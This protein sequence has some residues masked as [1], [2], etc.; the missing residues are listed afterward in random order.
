MITM[1]Y[2][3]S[4]SLKILL[5]S[6]RISHILNLAA[7]SRHYPGMPF[8]SLHYIQA[9]GMSTTFS[10]SDSPLGGPFRI[11]QCERAGVMRN[12]SMA[13]VGFHIIDFRVF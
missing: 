13:R 3:Y 1:S 11:E 9:I 6:P 12:V 2:G 10:L 4:N 8:P 5:M 7:S